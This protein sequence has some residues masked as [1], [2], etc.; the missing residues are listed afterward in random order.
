[1]VT[2]VRFIYSLFSVPIFTSLCRFIC[3]FLIHS[4]SLPLYL[5]SS[6]SL[7][8]SFCFF[9]CSLSLFLFLLLTLSLH[10]SPLDVS[11]HLSKSLSLF[12]FPFRFSFYLPI[13]VFVPPSL[14]FSLSLMRIKQLK[15]QINIQA[16]FANLWHIDK[17]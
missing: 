12:Y 15:R 17:L 9:I 2:L 5:S 6:L 3:L 7:F 8:S 14:Y 1:M 11:I 13:S 10:L 16:Y 4:L